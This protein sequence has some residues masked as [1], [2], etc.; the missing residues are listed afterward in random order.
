MTSGLADSL[1]IDQADA[2]A[3]ADAA[4]AHGRALTDLPAG[5]AAAG[6][7]A[8]FAGFRVG[9]V[10]AA[11]SEDARTALGILGSALDT[12]GGNTVQCVDAFHHTDFGA[13]VNIVNAITRLP[14]S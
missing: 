6:V 10:C 8:G 1:S 3:L 12:L 5:T 14:V 7:T 4:R 13:R 11:R 9:A 2:L